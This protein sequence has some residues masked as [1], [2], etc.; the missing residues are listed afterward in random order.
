MAEPPKISKGVLGGG[1]ESYDD[2]TNQ[3]SCQRNRLS[4][5]NAVSSIDTS[6]AILSSSLRPSELNTDLRLT[7]GATST[8]SSSS[9]PT[10]QSPTTHTNSYDTGKLWPTDHDRP[11]SLLQRGDFT[12]TSDRRSLNHRIKLSQDPIVW[13]ERKKLK[14]T[15]D[16]TST[17]HSLSV[18]S[19]SYVTIT[20]S[21]VSITSNS[22]NTKR[23]GDIFGRASANDVGCDDDDDD[24]DDI[25]G[26]PTWEPLVPC[27]ICNQTIVDDET[28]NCLQCTPA[29][30]S[31]YAAVQAL[32]LENKQLTIAI[33]QVMQRREARVEA[34]IK[35]NVSRK[36]RKAIERVDD[37]STILQ[38]LATSATRAAWDEGVEDDGLIVPKAVRKMEKLRDRERRRTR[39]EMMKRLLEGLEK[40]VS[41]MKSLVASRSKLQK[42]STQNTFIYTAS[43]SMLYISPS[44]HTS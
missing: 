24:G 35:R 27:Y 2:N 19:Y 33:E 21:N 41:T 18:P 23:K 17:S 44:Y 36:A 14:Q 26:S 13:D 9:L 37:D 20:N 22:N 39:V 1:C 10:I 15:E 3:S 32:E 12:V 34:R 8:T 28:I 29:A 30:L 7:T 42:V 5:G 40:E 25:P 11:V 4:T 38:V 43:I 6:S 16:D 31:V